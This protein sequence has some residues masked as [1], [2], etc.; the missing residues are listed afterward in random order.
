MRTPIKFSSKNL[1]RAARDPNGARRIALR[2]RKFLAAGRWTPFVGVEREGVRYILS[3]QETDGVNF[4]TFVRGVFDEE[5]VLRMSLALKQHTDISTLRGLT[6][7]EV[8]ANIGTETVS[9]L[10]RHAVS[11]VVAIEPGSANVQ[12]LRANLAVNGMQDRV[13]IHQ[14]ALSET[15]GPLMLECSE[16]NQGDHRIR[17]AASGPDL[18]NEGQ[19]IAVEVIGRSLDSLTDAGEIDL[20]GIDLMWMDA[21][22]H[23]AHIL[24]GAERLV[25][26]DIPVLTEY[27]PYGLR[28]VNALDR[29]HDL[30]SERYSKVIDLRTGLDEPAVVLDAKHV[31]ELADRYLPGA[32]EDPVAPY[33]DL[34]LLSA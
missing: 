6:V 3:T 24:A 31:A 21:Q 9:M 28:R 16:Q 25:A 23:E 34:L 29:F 12:L 1:M 7:L 17:M 2:A 8:G 22:G 18:R 13:Q 32:R 14:M 19:R 11:N 27:W 4:S 26:T 5:T 10:V 15:D 20:D 33:T 30:V